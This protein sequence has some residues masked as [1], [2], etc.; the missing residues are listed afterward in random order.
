MNSLG[1]GSIMIMRYR[2]YYLTE[3]ADYK[4]LCF[5]L[6]K[7]PKLKQHFFNNSNCIII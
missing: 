3:S 2:Y 7:Y 5:L 4:I 6:T 1:G